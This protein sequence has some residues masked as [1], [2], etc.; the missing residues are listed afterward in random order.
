MKGRK[1]IYYKS[2]ELWVYLQETLDLPKQSLHYH[3][4]IKEK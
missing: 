3:T 1:V 2:V 4:K